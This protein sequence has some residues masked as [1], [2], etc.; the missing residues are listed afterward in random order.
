M[1]YFIPRDKSERPMQRVTVTLDDELVAEIDQLVEQERF[2]IV[3][4]FLVAA[5]V[6]F[7]VSIMLAGTIA[8]DGNQRTLLRARVMKGDA[9][10]AAQI[11]S[12]P[13][14]ILWLT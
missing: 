9:P 4:V 6:M 13:R 8:G 14:V 10:A 3:R 5:V 12:S 1:S 7:V 11:S 2:V